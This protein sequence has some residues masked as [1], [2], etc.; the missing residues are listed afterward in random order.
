[1]KICEYKF[2][3]GERCE[4]E[5]LP[6]S[7]Y[8]I[9]HID[10]P[11]DTTSEEFKRINKL[12]LDKVVEKGSKGGFNFEGT[13]LWAGNV[14][15]CIPSSLGTVEEEIK[16]TE[17]LFLVALLSLILGG[18][19]FLVT[20]KHLLSAVCLIGVGFF[21]VPAFGTYTFKEPIWQEYYPD[22]FQERFLSKEW[23][24]VLVLI[25]GWIVIGVIT[26]LITITL[27]TFLLA[28]GV[29]V[30]S[31][32]DL[33]GFID[34]FIGVVRLKKP[35]KTKI[36]YLLSIGTV[37]AIGIL[38]AILSIIQNIIIIGLIL[39]LIAYCLLFRG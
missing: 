10:L 25:I 18:V 14:Q 20:T 32:C 11:E 37:C 1:M 4:E 23:N 6:N 39:L 16:T 34:T 19:P 30:M 7:K 28:V 27:S 2:R 33:K 26:E 8:C 24:W 12:K 5:A 36:I 35:K 15:I 21:L 17:K 3:N 22:R 38:I 31:I 29:L 13:K 9:L